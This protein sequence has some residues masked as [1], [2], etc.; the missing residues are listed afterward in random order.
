MMQPIF[1]FRALST[2]IACDCALVQAVNIDMRNGGGSLFFSTT[3]R[4][5]GPGHPGAFRYGNGQIAFAYHFYDSQ[6]PEAPTPELNWASMGINVLTFEDGWPV[7]GAEL[8][9]KDILTVHE[10]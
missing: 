1:I 5:V 6:H 4:F 10:P 8:H 2:L 3:D 9:P 7:L